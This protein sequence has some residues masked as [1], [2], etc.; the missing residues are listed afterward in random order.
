MMSKQFEAQR[1]DN[2]QFMTQILTK[3]EEAINAI[4]S[5]ID[6]RLNKIE[7]QMKSTK[8]EYEND[9]S[10]A[11]SS[12]ES[13]SAANAMKRVHVKADATKPEAFD[14]K[15]GK[16]RHSK[17]TAFKDTADFYIKTTEGDGMLA[18]SDKVA[19]LI[20]HMRAPAIHH[21]I[22]IRQQLL[23]K[24][25]IT[26]LTYEDFLTKLDQI[27]ACKELHNVTDLLFNIAQ[28]PDESVGEY[29][30]R[31]SLLLNEM[32]I[33]NDI[34]KDVA[35]NLFINGL[36]EVLKN[37]VNYRRLADRILDTYSVDQAEEAVLRCCH[38]A[39]AEEAA[40][41]GSGKAWLLKP[42]LPQKKS[43]NTKQSNFQQAD[44]SVNRSNNNGSNAS[45]SYGSSTHQSSA[46]QP[47]SSNNVPSATPRPPKCYNCGQLGHFSKICKSVKPT[48]NMFDAV[49]DEETEATPSSAEPESKN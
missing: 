36:F 7:N 45:K 23:A 1:T 13:V 30:D 2:A 42:K 49:A 25:P 24:A 39:A 21:A 38:V 6:K 19:L 47:R 12:V 43:F 35:V 28:Q 34:S 9:N 31:F 26:Q 33:D 48:L 20:Q 27:F 37:K 5:S 18:E 44:A 14:G 16:D 46:P 22:R 3:N 29:F 32:M 10:D 41:H 11:A 17:W 40:I 4:V 8:E 15:P